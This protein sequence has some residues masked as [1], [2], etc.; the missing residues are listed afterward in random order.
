MQTVLRSRHTEFS[1]HE[2]WFGEPAALV[3]AQAANQPA[4]QF[5]A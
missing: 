1:S 4:Q 3:F 2:S 5:P